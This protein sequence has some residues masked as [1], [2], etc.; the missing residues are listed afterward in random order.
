MAGIAHAGLGCH[1]GATLDHDHLMAALAEEISSGDA[2]DAG[3]QHDDAHGLG[4]RK[5]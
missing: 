2:D 5:R 3:A 4:L 1:L